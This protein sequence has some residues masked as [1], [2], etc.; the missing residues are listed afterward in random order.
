MKSKSKSKTTNTYAYQAP[1]QTQQMQQYGQSIN[2]AYD[3][4][5]PSIG[6]QFASA[7]GRIDDRFDNPFGQDY[8]PEVQDAMKYSGHQQLDQAQGQAYREDAFRRKEGK[9]GHQAAYAG[10]TA[11]QLVQTGG[12]FQGSQS[13]PWGPALIGAA[14][15]TAGGFLS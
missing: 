4:P 15:T 8:S 6:Y 7:R 9:L 14:G 11:P 1:P 10:M 12:T 13:Q 2:D 3:T 5:D